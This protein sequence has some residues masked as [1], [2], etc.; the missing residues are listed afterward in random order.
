MNV[1]AFCGSLS[2]SSICEF[3]IHRYVDHLNAH[4]D[5]EINLFYINGNSLTINYNQ[6]SNQEFYHGHSTDDT[7][8]IKK[9]EYQLIKSDIIIFASPIYMH[10]VSGFMKNFI[11]SSIQYEAKKVMRKIRS[12]QFNITDFHEKNLKPIK[13]CIIHKILQ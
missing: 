12:K 3:A 7:D 5:V 2:D 11:D 9:L 8:D 6:G 1:C 13:I 4:S 10:S